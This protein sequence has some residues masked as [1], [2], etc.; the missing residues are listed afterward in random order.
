M[1]VERQDNW[2][3]LWTDCCGGIRKLNGRFDVDGRD[4]WR[5]GMWCGS[6][7]YC[8]RF[9]VLGTLLKLVCCVV[10]DAFLMPTVPVEGGRTD[11]DRDDWR[12][13]CCAAVCRIFYDFVFL[14]QMVGF[15]ALFVFACCLAYMVCM[16]TVVFLG[17]VR[18]EAS[19]QSTF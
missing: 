8:L 10:Y 4:S 6:V 11:G 3:R 18:S 16:Y 14:H 15:I 7:N 13:C 2:R 17:D 5:T 9:F 12:G 1:R 19:R